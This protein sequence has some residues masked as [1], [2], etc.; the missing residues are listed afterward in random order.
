MVC[1]NFTCIFEILT[2]LR[3]S[4]RLH[5]TVRI[6]VDLTKSSKTIICHLENIYILFLKIR[7]WYW[8]LTL[9]QL[10][11]VWSFSCEK[12]VLSYKLK[13]QSANIILLTFFKYILTFF[14]I[15]ARSTFNIQK[16]AFLLTFTNGIY[17]I[18]A[19]IMTIR[20]VEFSNGG[21]KIR[22]IFV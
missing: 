20:V 1:L 2:R 3:K 14:L 4:F 22:K 15:G 12:N 5:H 19:Y 11:G 8:V 9:K 18:Y 7:S 16:I 21:Y 6:Y 13:N 17:Y 10:L